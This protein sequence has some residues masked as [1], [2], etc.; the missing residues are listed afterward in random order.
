VSKIVRMRFFLTIMFCFGLLALVAH[1][2]QV[3]V[4]SPAKLRSIPKIEYPERAKQ[5][6]ISGSVTI[7]ARIALDGKVVSAQFASGPGIICPSVT[8]PAVVELRESALRAVRAAKFS[9]DT[10]KIDPNAVDVPAILYVDFPELKT[11]GLKESKDLDND[12]GTANP[13]GKSTGF[14]LQEKIDPSPKPVYPAAARAVQASGPV[15][16]R[17][18]IDEDGSVF[19]SEAISGHPLL[20]GAAASAACGARFIPTI[21]NGKPTRISGILTYNFVP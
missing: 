2:Q 11:N 1:G 18:I 9:I 5:A 7:R 21:L 16:V 15:Q 3:S 14:T 19:S 20:R 8:L 4:D 6:G 10:V 17:L 12:Y 13:S